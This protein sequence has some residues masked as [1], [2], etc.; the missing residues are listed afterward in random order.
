MGAQ[1]VREIMTTDVVTLPVDTTLV[2]AARVMRERDIG[3]VVVVEAERL[4][5]VV[6]DRDIVLR[7]VA[8]GLAPEATTVGAVVSQ[9][10]VTVRPD[11]RV[12][13]AA[14]VMRERA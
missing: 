3:D 14:L 6:T 13:D 7:A 11:D 9:D 8:E 4:I 12:V 2:D 1:T 5:G 10:L